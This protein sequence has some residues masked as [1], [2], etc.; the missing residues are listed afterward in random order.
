M[1]I[2]LLTLDNLDFKFNEVI[3]PSVAF[4]VTCAGSISVEVTYGTAT[5]K[6]PLCVC[7]DNSIT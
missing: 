2:L 1:H 3:F 5:G 7:L 6:L 4:L